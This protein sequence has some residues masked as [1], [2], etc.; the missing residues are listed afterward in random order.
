M[1]FLGKRPQ[2]RVVRPF[3]GGGGPDSVREATGEA[4]DGAQAAEEGEAAAVPGGGRPAGRGAR[5]PQGGGG[6][7]PPVP[8]DGPFPFA[9]VRLSHQL[10]WI[11]A[12][13]SGGP[14]PCVFGA[15]LF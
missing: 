7:C 3:T 11:S 6:R 5:G 13:G 10:C 8:S 9:C 12:A 4:Q 1:A 14:T 2:K 15:E